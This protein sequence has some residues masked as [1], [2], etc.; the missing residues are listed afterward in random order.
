[1]NS[2]ATFQFETGVAA[3]DPSCVSPATCNVPPKGAAFYP[4]YSIQTPGGAHAKC[5]LMFGDLMGSGLPGLNSYG[6]DFQYGTADTVTGHFPEHLGPINANP[7]L[8]Q[9][10]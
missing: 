3:S 1:V 10:Q 2:Y 4:Y 6:A 9:T 8:D 7:C 5:F